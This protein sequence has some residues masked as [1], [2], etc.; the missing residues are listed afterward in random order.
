M[1]SLLERFKSCYKVHKEVS[2]DESVIGFKDRLWFIQNMPNKPTKWE[3]KAFVLAD[4]IS[5][6]T[7]SWQLYAG[8]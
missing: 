7:N 4:S 1:E 5:A 8:K 6:Y 2:E 3:M